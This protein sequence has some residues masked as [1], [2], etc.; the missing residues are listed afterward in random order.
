M[1]G[2][3]ERQQVMAL[4]MVERTLA[5]IDMDSLAAAQKAAIAATTGTAVNYLRSVF[6]PDDGR[7]FC[8]FEGPDADAVRRVNDAAA[9][10]YD[11]VTSAM[12]L[13]KPLPAGDKFRPLE[14]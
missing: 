10:P 6:A 14:R 12:D 5:G 13:P 9:L 1:S 2:L 7:C 4:Y 3:N 11:R 8:L